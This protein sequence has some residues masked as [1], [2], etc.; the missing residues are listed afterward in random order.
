MIGFLIGIVTSIVAAAPAV[1]LERGGR[2][3]DAKTRWK[4]WGLGVLLRFGIIGASLYFL[5]TET[6]V[7]RIP[8]VIGVALAYFVVFIIENINLRRS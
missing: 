1:F 5:F 4:L 2:Y 3:A 8:T 7:S 6:S